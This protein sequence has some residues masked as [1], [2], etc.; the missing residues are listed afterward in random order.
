[1]FLGST[2]LFITLTVKSQSVD[3]ICHLNVQ[4][5]IEKLRIS[6]CLKKINYK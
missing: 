5:D 2:Y 3:K 4:D 6:L 1:M